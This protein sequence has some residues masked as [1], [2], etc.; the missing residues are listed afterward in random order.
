MYHLE[1]ADC[2]SRWCVENVSPFLNGAIKAANTYDECVHVN[3]V[4]R[5]FRGISRVA[6]IKASTRAFYIEG[7][8]FQTRPFWTW[9]SANNYCKKH[10]YSHRIF[11]MG[12]WAKDG[13]HV[14]IAPNEYLPPVFEEAEEAIAYAKGWLA[15]NGNHKSVAEIF[16]YGD[17]FQFINYEVP[18]VGRMD[19]VAKFLHDHQG[20]ISFEKE[21]Q[22]TCRFNFNGEEREKSFTAE[23]TVVPQLRDF[24]N[25]V[26]RC[27]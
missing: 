17:H 8:Q 6:H 21:G 18:C 4:E 15:G 24:I 1:C 16:C 11:Q 22:F 2:V 19:S 25:E 12:V 9:A 7:K 10:N 27:G 14:R 13:Y 3:I 23:V 5:P 26:L 20:E